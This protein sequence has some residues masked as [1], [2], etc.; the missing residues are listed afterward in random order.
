VQPVGTVGRDACWRPPVGRSIQRPV[1][2]DHDPGA[3]G[4]RAPREIAEDARAENSIGVATQGDAIV[5]ERSLDAVGDHVRD[6]RSLFYGETDRRRIV[7]GQHADG[8]PDD[9]TASECS[10]HDHLNRR[11]VTDA[12]SNVVTGDE[13]DEGTARVRA[14]A[15]WRVVVRGENRVVYDPHGQRVGS[16]EVGHQ[17]LAARQRESLDVD[18]LVAAG[19][20]G[21]RDDAVVLG[22][23]GLEAG[24]RP[25]VRR[26]RGLD[27]LVDRP[28]GGDLHTVVHRRG[29]DAR[30]E[31][32][33]GRA[34]MSQAR[35]SRSTTSSAP[36]PIGTSRK[37][38]STSG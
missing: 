11:Q 25:Q 23:D 19:E 2:L 5:I 28:V 21:V 8:I 26:F 27:R 15:N 34:P 10:I 24:R 12:R 32:S 37:R 16:A 30:L 14:Y 7:D 33:V 4:V 35:C 1:S 22:E 13:K 20:G 18:E 31:G 9:V 17:D 3:A 38:A 36:E 6:E 29:F